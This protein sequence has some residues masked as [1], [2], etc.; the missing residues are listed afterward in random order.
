MRG[1]GTSAFG[2]VFVLRTDAGDLVVSY[3]SGELWRWS[4]VGLEDRLCEDVVYAGLVE[5]SY[6]DPLFASRLDAVSD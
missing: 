6:D 3:A 2:F 1:D 4:V 5:V